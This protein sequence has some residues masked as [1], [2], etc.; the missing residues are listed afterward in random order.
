[1]KLGP[2]W[3]INYPLTSP[4][5]LEIWRKLQKKKKQNRKHNSNL[6]I[7]ISLQLKSEIISK[8]LHDNFYPTVMKFRDNFK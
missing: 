4:N 6:L 1:M 3:A 7:V 2:Q 5:N 8:R